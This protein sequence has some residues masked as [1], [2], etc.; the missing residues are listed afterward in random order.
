MKARI[1]ELARLALPFL[2]ILALTL[3]WRSKV[4]RAMLE[5]LPDRLEGISTLPG[6]EALFVG[7]F[8]VSGFA[9]VPLSALIV[10]TAAALGPVEGA[11]V[12]W[13]GATASSIVIFAVG[14]V[15][16]RRAFRDLVG[17]QGRNV[18]DRIAG[19]GILAVAILRNL[20]VA[21]FTVVDLA[22]DCPLAQ[23]RFR[24][25]VL[26]TL[27]GLIPGIA[28]LTLVGDRLMAA[29]RSPSPGHLALLAGAI[30]AL[31][32]LGMVA[33]RLTRSSDDTNG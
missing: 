28:I 2:V 3:A 12:S 21:P 23:L 18:A 24:D 1:A 29:L 13:V 16:G 15:C 7:V 30:L 17:K 22:A 19:Q 10:A 26:G 27:I 4:M 14:R 5:S 25:F 11:F 20:P 31:V 6:A 32:V 33:S 8:I 9:A